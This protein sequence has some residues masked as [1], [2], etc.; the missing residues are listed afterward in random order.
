MDRAEFDKFADEYAH[1]HARNIR[2]SGEGPEYFAEY[3]VRDV[4]EYLSACGR[5]AT[6][7]LDF[8]AGVGTSI[9]WFRRHL[10]AA[11]LTCL[12]VSERSLH[13]GASRFPDQADFVSFDGQRI[14]LADASFDV[15]F[16]ACV[17]HHIDAAQQ[18]GLLREIR[19]VLRPDGVFAIFE[20][21]PMNPL[22]VRA[23]NS[24]EFDDNAVLIHPSTLRRR[25]RQAGFVQT[26]LR[27]RIFFPH[28]ARSLRGLE[29]A[30][31]WCPVGAQY[32]VFASGGHAAA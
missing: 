25:L 21:N 3:K 20:H 32:S 24:C 13:V 4:A 19:R 1:I 6:T 8:G 5:T 11:K 17:F 16:A 18:V 31:R 26:R 27:Y 7:V 2:I 30:L 14:P 15:A 10:D 29:R 28:A 23:V 12:D 9:P 22:T